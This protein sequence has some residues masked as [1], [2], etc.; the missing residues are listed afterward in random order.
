MGACVCVHAHVC[1]CVCAPACVCV[2][3][4]VP[5]CAHVCQCVRVCARLCVCMPLCACVCVCVCVRFMCPPEGAQ[6]VISFVPKALSM[7]TGPRP[8]PLWPET[9]RKRAVCGWCSM[10][11]PRARDTPD[12]REP[13]DL[14]ANP[15]V[16]ALLCGPACSG[17]RGQAFQSVL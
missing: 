16:F 11:T 10:L 12:T 7:L 15:H 4:R 6:V 13:R 9:R 2:C 14:C 8:P 5:V 17:L 3:T 1:V